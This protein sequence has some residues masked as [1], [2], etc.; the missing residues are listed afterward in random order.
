MHCFFIHLGFDARRSAESVLIIVG[1]A[2]VERA[3]AG[4]GSIL[5]RMVPLGGKMDDCTTVVALVHDVP[6]SWDS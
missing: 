3:K 5:Q 1:A 2:A 6:P 4:V